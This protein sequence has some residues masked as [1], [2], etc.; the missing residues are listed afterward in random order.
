MSAVSSIFGIYQI[1]NKV[2]GETYV[3]SSDNVQKRL[4]DHMISLA[5][6]HHINKMLQRSWKKYGPESHIFEVLE[7]VQEKNELSNREIFWINKTDSLENGFNTKT[8]KCKNRT[9]I[10]IHPE[11]KI[12]L[13]RLDMGSMSETLGQLIKY[14]LKFHD[15]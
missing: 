4:K 9:L 10:S 14:Y 13:E 1:K 12:E 15:K 2:T 6:G 11:T 8:D 3:G 5:R 7:E